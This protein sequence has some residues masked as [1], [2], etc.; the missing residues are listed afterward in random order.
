[1]PYFESNRPGYFPW[2]R[3][4]GC[5]EVG[6]PCSGLAASV[7][8]A[9]VPSA[10]PEPALQRWVNGLSDV[11]LSYRWTN[12]GNEPWRNYVLPDGLQARADRVT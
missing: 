1:M 9:P 3:R 7:A 11:P 5:G 12:P 8:A 2:Q 10:S 4:P 6:P